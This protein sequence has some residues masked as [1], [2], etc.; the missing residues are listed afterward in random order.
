[1]GKCGH[2][3]TSA[4]PQ[5]DP[6]DL[7]VQRLA[8]SLVSEVTTDACQTA[9]R[10]LTHSTATAAPTVAF[11]CSDS[12]S[13]SVQQLPVQ[14]LSRPSHASSSLSSATLFTCAILLVVASLVCH[15]LCKLFTYFSSLF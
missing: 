4:P 5:L 13:G 11:H 15:Y 10:I 12:L 1:M 14:G 2:R 8:E 9:D 6:L 7:V 3:L